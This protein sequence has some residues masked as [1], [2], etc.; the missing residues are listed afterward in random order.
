MK[1]NTTLLF[2]R[3]GLSGFYMLMVK[4]PIVAASIVPKLGRSILIMTYANRRETWERT[5]QIFT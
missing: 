2:R 4:C 1:E 3:A 5:L